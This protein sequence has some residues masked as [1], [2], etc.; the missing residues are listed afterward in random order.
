MVFIVISN[1]V[2]YLE[3]EH[4]HQEHFSSKDSL[5]KGCLGKRWT[6]SLYPVASWPFC[7]SYLQ[8][9]RPVLQSA[10]ANTTTGM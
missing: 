7:A 3:F 10:R 2:C 6:V 5:V 4:L 9:Q 1:L 8:T